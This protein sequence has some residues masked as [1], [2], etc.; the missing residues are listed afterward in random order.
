LHKFDGNK[1]EAFAFESCNNLPGQMPLDAIR[2]ND[3]QSPFR[4]SRGS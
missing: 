2:L 1:L 4:H 3:N